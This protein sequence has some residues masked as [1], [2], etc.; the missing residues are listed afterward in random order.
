MAEAYVFVKPQSGWINMTQTA[1]LTASV[2]AAW[3]GLSVATTGNLVAVGDYYYGSSN[4]G[5]EGAT[6]IYTKPKGGWKDTSHFE[7]NLT[8]S[9]ARFNSD[10]GWSVAAQG[11]TV[12]AGSPGL[13]SGTNYSGGAFI[14]F[15]PE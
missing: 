1:K 12:V 4:F 5:N 13:M 3:F 7:A 8:G 9:D 15:L 6:F 10:L 2:Q 14:F 11:N